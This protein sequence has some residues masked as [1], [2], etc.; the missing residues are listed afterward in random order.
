M[1]CSVIHVKSLTISVPP[2]PLELTLQFCVYV[3]CNPEVP[4]T[5]HRLPQTPHEPKVKGRMH[6]QE[7][8]YRTMMQYFI[9]FCIHSTDMC[10]C[11]NL[12]NHSEV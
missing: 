1:D 4:E 11:L 7:S 6:W 12:E 8:N 5:P 9:M 10:S 2:P 3:M